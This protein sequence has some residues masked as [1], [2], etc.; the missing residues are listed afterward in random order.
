[1]QGSGWL[2]MLLVLPVL[3]LLQMVLLVLVLLQMVL[4]VLASINRLQPQSQ[5][6]TLQQRR[7]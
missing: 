1:V 4:L 2:V 5:P 3:V 7:R 6:Q